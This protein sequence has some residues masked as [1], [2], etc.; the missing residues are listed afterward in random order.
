MGA[1]VVEFGIF[2]YLEAMSWQVLIVTA[3]SALLVPDQK[4]GG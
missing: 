2:F 4:Y 3:L 1:I